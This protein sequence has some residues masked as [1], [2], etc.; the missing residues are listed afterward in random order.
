MKNRPAVIEVKGIENLRPAMLIDLFENR[1]LAI[2]IPGYYP[3]DLSE[4]VSNRLIQHPRF[5]YYAN[6][7]DIGRV[8]MAYFETIDSPARRAHY[9]QEARTAMMDMRGCCHPYVSPVDQLRIDIAEVWPNGANLENIEGQQMFVGLARV[10]TDGAEALPHQDILRRDA[11]HCPRAATLTGQVAANIY[12]RPTPEGGELEI[13]EQVI[14][15]NEYE[16]LRIP[17]SYGLDRSRLSSPAATLQPREGELVLFN[18]RCV[19]AVRPAKGGAR[20][21]LSC[22]L[23]YRG[24]DQAL[25]YWS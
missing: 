1:L 25:S 13:W 16:Q 9:Y 2:R 23:G 5:G 12:L 24:Q 17:D 14:N 8:G 19:H 4:T 11:P 15:D 18:S 20:I 7:E 6:A 3:E 10:F 22:F 21:T